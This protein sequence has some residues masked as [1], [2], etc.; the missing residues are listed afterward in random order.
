MTQKASHARRCVANEGH[1]EFGL[2]IFLLTHDTQHIKAVMKY[3]VLAAHQTQHDWEFSSGIR[4]CETSKAETLELRQSSSLIEFLGDQS[5]RKQQRTHNRSINQSIDISQSSVLAL[6]SI[7]RR[8]GAAKSRFSEKLVDRP[9]SQCHTSQTASHS[10]QN[11][12]HFDDSALV[13][14]SVIAGY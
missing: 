6:N 11:T 7:A 9:V 3:R 14:S 2:I 4:Y 10:C 12:F 1:D 13:Q 8:T 5:S